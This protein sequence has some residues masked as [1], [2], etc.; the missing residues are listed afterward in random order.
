MQPEMAGA[1]QTR[2]GR[3]SPR[4]SVSVSILCLAALAACGGSPRVATRKDDPPWWRERGVGRCR[5]VPYV[6]GD[7][8]RTYVPSGSRYLNDHSLIM[9]PDGTWHVYGIT[10]DS[11]GDPEA[12]HQFLH[13]TAPSLFGP[14]TEQPDALVADPRMNEA[15]LWAPHVVEASAGRWA[16]FYYADLLDGDPTRGVRRAE[17]TDLWHWQRVEATASPRARPPGGRDPFL[18]R[19]ADRWLLFSVGVDGASHG[20]ILSSQSRD[21]SFDEWSA[22]SPVITDPVATGPWRRGNLQ[23]PFVVTHDEQF[24]LFVTRKS[25]SPIDYVRTNVFCSDD[26]RHFDW[27]PIAELRAHAAEIVVDHGRSF[28]TSGGWTKAIGEDHRGLSIAPLEWAPR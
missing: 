16:L 13:A 5:H 27:Q 28:I 23:S 7:F 1:I 2:V 19:G 22:A 6:A 15:V 21:L 9:G 26:P 8:Y 10:N 12:E 17:S 18:F 3:G 25:P 4:R 11:A 14:W 20:Q 24:Y